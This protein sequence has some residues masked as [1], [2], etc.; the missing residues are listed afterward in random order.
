MDPDLQLSRDP[1]MQVGHY[2]HGLYGSL[3]CN[4]CDVASAWMQFELT[5]VSRLF[6]LRTTSYETWCRGTCNIRSDNTLGLKL[7]IRL[8]FM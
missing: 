4:L 7:L 3:Q 6:Y 8:Q 5:E 1:V 2:T